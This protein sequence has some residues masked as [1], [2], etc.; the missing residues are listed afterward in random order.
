MFWVTET[1][2]YK[3]DFFVVQIFGKNQKDFQMR[4]W[5]SLKILGVVVT[6]VVNFP[7]FFLVQTPTRGKHA[8]ANNQHLTCTCKE[9][10]RALSEHCGCCT[11]HPI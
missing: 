4:F 3:I 10:T 2:H 6:G 9:L 1:Q 5:G 8:H 7:N 11:G